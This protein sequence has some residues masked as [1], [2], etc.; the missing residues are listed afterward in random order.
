MSAENI[1]EI[2]LFFLFVFIPLIVGLIKYTSH[3]IRA[4][5][6]RNQWERHDE[7]QLRNYRG[8]PPDWGLRRALTIKRA[9]GICEKCGVQCGR[10]AVV[11]WKF[12]FDRQRHLKIDGHVH[13][14]VAIS[15]GGN[16]QLDNL[17]LLCPR[18]HASEHPGNPNI[19]QW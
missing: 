9:R 8:Y 7:R 18:C 19:L 11:I 12:H 13:H 17:V 2:L 16:H 10:R 1:F 15:K 4:R 14:I 5:A 3:R 6:N